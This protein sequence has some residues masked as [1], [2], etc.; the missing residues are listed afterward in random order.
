M[1][2]ADVAEARFDG[3]GIDLQI[4]RIPTATD[5]VPTSPQRVGQPKTRVDIVR[6]G[7]D[8]GRERLD[9]LLMLADLLV[10]HAEAVMR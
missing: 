10:H 3:A 6:L 7:L 4:A 9:R 1:S 5:R 8:G 2:A